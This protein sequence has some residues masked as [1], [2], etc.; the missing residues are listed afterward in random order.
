MDIRLE[1]IRAVH[2]TKIEKRVLGREE[3]RGPEAGE[4]IQLVS[5]Q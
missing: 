5:D 1:G 4:M 3:K 2:Q